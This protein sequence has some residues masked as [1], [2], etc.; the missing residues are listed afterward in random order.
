MSA[1]SKL[2]LLSIVALSALLSSGCE[3][4]ALANPP[5]Q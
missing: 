5:K 3:L 2:M 4:D 1:S